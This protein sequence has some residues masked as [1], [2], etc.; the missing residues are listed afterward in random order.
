MTKR[1]MIRKSLQA[2]ARDLGGIDNS[3]Y[4]VKI[5]CCQDAIEN[6]I[7]KEHS[8]D[9]VKSMY[10]DTLRGDFYYIAQ[11]VEKYFN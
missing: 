10:H 11:Q 7:N 4:A 9:F 2:Y 3:D 5:Y 6:K 8:A 1:E